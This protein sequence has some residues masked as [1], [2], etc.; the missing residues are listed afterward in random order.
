MPSRLAYENWTFLCHLQCSQCSHVKCNGQRC[1][2]RVCIGTPTCWIHTIQTLGVRVRPSNEAGAGKGLFTTTPRVM[3]EWI[4]PYI[5]ETITQACLDKRY[6][7]DTTATYTVNASNERHHTDSACQRGIGAMAN[8]KFDAEGFS[9]PRNRHNAV[10]ETRDG[11]GLWLQA[12]RRIGANR[13]IFVHYGD[14]YVLDD[15]HS[16]KRTTR[17]DDRP[18]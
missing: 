16:T 13:E 4:C 18:C 11:E 1:R 12:T 9:R 5:G 2:N 6:P 14:D 15:D 3:G 10:I 8:G 7:G 17:E